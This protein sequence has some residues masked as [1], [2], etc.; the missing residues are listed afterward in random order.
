MEKAQFSISPSKTTIKYLDTLVEIFIRYNGYGLDQ[1][2]S[3]MQS[4][5]LNDN[6]QYI[7]FMDAWYILITMELIE[8]RGGLWFYK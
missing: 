8:Q 7:Y 5:M 1:Y 2:R 4:I 6:F 3:F